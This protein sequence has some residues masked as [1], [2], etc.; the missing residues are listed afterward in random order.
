MGRIARRSNAN[1]M[2]LILSFPG[3]VPS[4]TRPFFVLAYSFGSDV[5][6]NLPGGLLARRLNSF[7]KDRAKPARGAK[8]SQFAA[9]AAP[10]IPAAQ[11]RLF[12]RRPFRI[13]PVPR[14]ARVRMLLLNSVP[15]SEMNSL[16]EYF[17][18]L[19]L[20]FFAGP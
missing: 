6:S 5:L 7:L 16:R 13:P 14:L 3:R 17:L 18:S 12:G 19:L 10:I 20:S 15:Y 11:P 9:L 8:R 1:F 4:G 2:R